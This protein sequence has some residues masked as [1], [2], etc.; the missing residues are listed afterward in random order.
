MIALFWTSIKA[1]W[2]I[3]LTR[4]IYFRSDVWNI[5][6]EDPMIHYQSRKSQLEVD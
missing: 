1:E 6:M 4:L 3:L 2:L 5:K